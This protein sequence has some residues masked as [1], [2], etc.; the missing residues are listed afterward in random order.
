M[1]EKKKG[2]LKTCFG[3]SVSCNSDRRSESMRLKLWNVRFF[4]MVFIIKMIFMS[5][6]I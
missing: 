5:F 4:N 3:D 6:K 2:Q 1:S